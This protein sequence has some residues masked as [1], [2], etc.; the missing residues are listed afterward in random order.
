MKILVFGLPGSGKTTL[1]EG[2]ANLLSGVHINADE[3]RMKYEG[4]DVHKWDFSLQGRINQANRMKYL[5]EGVVMAGKIAVAD[6]ICPTNEARKAFDADFTIWMD[7]IKQGRYEDTNRMF[8]K[9]DSVDYHV[10]QWFNDTHVQLIDVV[11]S[12]MERHNIV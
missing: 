12:Y 3:V 1:S 9:P 7:T 10:S 8:E 4:R 11:K 5:S 6:F 2:L